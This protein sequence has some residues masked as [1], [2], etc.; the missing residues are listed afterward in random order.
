MPKRP[1]TGPWRGCVSAWARIS[2]PRPI[3][4]PPQDRCPCPQGCGQR[5]RPAPSAPE[6]PLG[7]ACPPGLPGGVPREAPPVWATGWIRAGSPR[8]LP[9]RTARRWTRTI[10]A[11]RLLQAHHPPS[12]APARGLR[13]AQGPLDPP[14]PSLRRRLRAPPQGSGPPGPEARGPAMPAAAPNPCS[15]HRGIAPMTPTTGAPNSPGWICRFGGSAGAVI[16]RPSTCGERSATPA[17]RGSPVT[18]ICR[19]TCGCS[20]TFRQERIRCW[21][22][23]RCGGGT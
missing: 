14:R 3:Q 23:C 7:P 6:L 20:T 11:L 19:P 21:L 10:E 12:L 22:P 15:G 16:R 9:G 2:P 13:V 1:R 17:A 18:A 4:P 8:H 5:D